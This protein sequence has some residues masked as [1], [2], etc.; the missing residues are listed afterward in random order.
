MFGT[1]NDPRQL[2][3]PARV[4]AADSASHATASGSLLSAEADDAV[5]RHS[6]ARSRRMRRPS[7]LL[8][9]G[10]EVAHEAETRTQQEPARDVDITDAALPH[11][12]STGND[13]RDHAERDPFEILSDVRRETAQSGNR[14]ERRFGLIP[15]MTLAGAALGAA[16]SLWWPAGYVATSEVMVDPGTLGT[17]AVTLDH[18]AAMTIIDSQARVLR[19]GTILGAVVDRLNL[20]ADSE[21]GAASTLTGLDFLFNDSQPGSDADRDQAVRNL[22]DAI[23]VERATGTSI[24]TISARSSDP[25]KS[26]LIANTMAELFVEEAGSGSSLAER[27]RAVEEAERAVETYKREHELVDA[28]GRLITDDE[29]VRLGE[30]LTAARNR[31]VELNARAAST[32]DANVD[33]IVTGSLP[34]QFS[35][36]TLADLRSRHAALKQQLDRVSVKL[37]PRHPER[38]AAQAELEGARQEIANEL[39]R[40]SGALQT[41]L[42]RAVEQEQQLASQL[43]QMKVRQG[44]IG[45]E[46]VALRE[47]EREATAR[48]EAYEQILREAQDSNGSS[49]PSGTSIVSAAVPPSTASGASMTTLA[50]AGGG[51]GLLAGLAMNRRR[52][53]DDTDDLKPEHDAT[54]ATA[55]DATSEPDSGKEA[56]AMHSYYAHP[57][58]GQAAPGAAQP[59]AAPTQHMPY[60]GQHQHAQPPHPAQA[61]QQPGPVAGWSMQP[62]P[63]APPGPPHYPYATY[64]QMP[65]PAPYDPWAHQ[66]APMQQQAFAPP[67]PSAPVQ[68]VVYVPMPMAPSMQMPAQQAQPEPAER[69]SPARSRDH[70]ERRANRRANDGFDQDRYVDEHA[71]AAIEEIRQSLREFREAIEDLADSRYDDRRF[72]T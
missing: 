24:I 69:V 11:A 38:L 30:Y 46:M 23:D 58:D 51:A 5:A 36:S 63:M 10:N 34:E 45:E 7:P 64:P 44:D 54:D 3:G 67:P 19:S 12:A 57:L 20:A 62:T 50:L 6:I 65:T 21:F 9:T 35:S 42:K 39:R 31:T 29:I 13:E 14:S 48:R 41:E 16:L 33:S 72:G 1:R 61:W 71:N 70:G 37:G 53:D 40:V 49:R 25:D 2:H 47:L 55:G 28:Q 68:T 66:R 56:D 17:G 52:R 8:A 60:A 26:A 27:R 22:S 43:A 59:Q 15:G 18:S 32:R 4:D